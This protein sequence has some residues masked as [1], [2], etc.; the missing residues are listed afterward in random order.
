MP[1]YLRYIF[2]LAWK[3]RR[4]CYGLFALLLMSVVMRLAEPYLYKVIVDTLAAGLINSLNFTA[5]QLQTLVIAV[6]IWF[7]IAVILNVTSAQAA[8][9]T[10]KIG[11]RSS[12]RVSMAGYR[13][14]LQLDY[15]EHIKRHSSKLS[16]IVDN[17]D[18]STWEMTNWW[19]SRFFSAILGFVGMLIIALSVSWQMTL[20]AISVIPPGLWFIMHHVKKYEAEQRRVNKLWEEK[21]EHLSD[22]VSN[23]ITY[24]LNPR[25]SIFL[26]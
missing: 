22:Q 19:L 26:S 10:W 5:S 13:R 8:Y 14:L 17:A 18:I 20:V 25:E 24:K 21:H 3:N 1:R 2:S 9:L 7:V 15:A 4:L 12:Q 11:N 6:A 16:K 23:V